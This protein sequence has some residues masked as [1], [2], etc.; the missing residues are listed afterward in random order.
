MNVFR[1][2]VLCPGEAQRLKVTTHPA[3]IVFELIRGFRAG[4]RVFWDI[5]PS[6]FAFVELREIELRSEMIFSNKPSS[7]A[8]L[9]ENITHIHIVAFK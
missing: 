1:I 5:N 4:A 6:V 2:H 8:S 3:F 9:T 7:V